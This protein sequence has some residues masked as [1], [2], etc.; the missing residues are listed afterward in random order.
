MCGTIIMLEPD[1]AS[2]RCRDFGQQFRQ[3]H[4]QKDGVRATIQETSRKDALSN[5]I[6][7]HYTSPNI[8][9]KSLLLCMWSCCKRILMRQNM[10]IVTIKQFFSCKCR[11][12]SD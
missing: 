10:C 6:I 7:M 2:N 5:Q 9:R 4:L 12:I 3:C 11:F 1:S 8:D